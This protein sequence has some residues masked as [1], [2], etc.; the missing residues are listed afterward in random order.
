MTVLKAVRNG[1]RRDNRPPGSLTRRRRASLLFLALA[2]PLG[3]ALVLPAEAGA[4]TGSAVASAPYCGITWGSQPAGSWT[5]SGAAPLITTRTGQHA[6]FDR[7][8]F[9]LDGPANGYQV[10]Y[11]D[12]IYPDTSGASPMS[13]HTA[14][15]ALMSVVLHNLA[16]DQA[17][18]PTYPHRTFDHVANVS[19]YRTLRDVVCGGSSEDYTGFA[20]GTRARL[21]FRVFVLAGPGTHSRIVIDVAHRW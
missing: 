13:P 9:E 7:L 17:G 12:E 6:C 3:A 18:Q 8:V 11:V 21:P 4:S 1:W 10:S 20:V 5:P 2:L 19:G 15:G 16:H 14:G